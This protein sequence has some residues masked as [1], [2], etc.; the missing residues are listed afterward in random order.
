MRRAVTA[1]ALV[2]VLGACAGASKVDPQQV[3]VKLLTFLHQSRPGVKVDVS[4]PSGVPVKAGARFTCSVGLEGDP[5][6]Y[7]V[8]IEN[9][10]GSNYD[11]AAQPTDPIFDTQQVATAVKQQEGAGTTVDCG[12]TRF[13]QVPVHKTFQ[14]RVAVNGVDEVLVATVTDP[15]GSVSFSAG[16]GAPGGTGGPPPT[17]V[18]RVTLPGG[19]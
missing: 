17:T 9:V 14:C 15:Q 16:G 13:V 19:G 6:S 4:C 2:C 8:R 10:S 5:T 11:I 1:A 12:A 7:T 3:D 18:P